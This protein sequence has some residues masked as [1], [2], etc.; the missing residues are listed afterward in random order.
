MVK[1]EVM[2]VRNLIPISMGFMLALLLSAPAKADNTEYINL[3]FQ[4]G[5]TF[6]GALN[7][8]SDY[9]HI[10]GVSGTLTDYMSAP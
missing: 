5:A 3:N 4:S 6:V 9:G 2:K 1:G 8:N 10:T 7:F